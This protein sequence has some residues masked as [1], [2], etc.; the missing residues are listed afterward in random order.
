M[1][2]ALDETVGDPQEREMNGVLKL[3]ESCSESGT[4]DTVVGNS[5]VATSQ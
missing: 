5:F 4:H 1:D 3:A 2:G